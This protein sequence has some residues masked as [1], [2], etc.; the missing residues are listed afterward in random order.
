LFACIQGYT[1]IRVENLKC[2][3]LTNPIGIDASHPRLN[4]Q[5]QSARAYIAVAG[6]YE[7]SINATMAYILFK[8]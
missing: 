3:Y 6:L 7:L 2:E 1:E 5:L 8:M 4:W